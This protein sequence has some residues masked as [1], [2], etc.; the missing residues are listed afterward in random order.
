M[1]K[2]LKK[3]FAVMTMTCMLFASTAPAAVYAEE[4]NT[5]VSTATTE[6][7]M[8]EEETVVVKPAA[9]INI[10]KSAVTVKKGKKYQLKY[11]YKNTSK[12]NIIWTTS[13]KK[14]V[15]VN[16]K[17]LIKVTGGGKAY[18]TARVKGTNIQDRVLVTGKNYYKMRFKTT[19]Y[20]NGRC[21]CGKWAGH[22]TASGKRPR[23]KHTIAV[24][25][26]VI[27]LGTKVKIGNIVYTAEDTG[28][29]GRVIDVYYSNHRA[30]SRHG[31]KW[32]TAKVYF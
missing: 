30:A 28:V 18:V 23:A 5:S 17:G 3:S 21:C 13:N 22:R 26:R 1:L 7:V 10:A 20:C 19:G 27:K 9:Y 32:V 4:V 11:S 2:I 24:D 15:V 14:V 12:S 8:Q 31:V 25:K 6:T 16:S 29:R